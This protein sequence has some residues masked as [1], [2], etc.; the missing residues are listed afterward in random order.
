MTAA[1]HL[2]LP[3]RPVR[4]PPVPEAEL[5]DRQREVLEGVIMGQTVNIYQTLVRH[6][7][8]AAAM[9]NLGRMLRGS[10]LSA[11]D[12]EILILRTGCNC[13]SAY[14]LAQHYRTATEIGMTPDDMVRIRIGPDAPGWDEFEAA[15]CRAAD[16]L[17]VEHTIR[18]ATWQILAAHYDEQQLIQATML[19]GYYHLVSFALNALGVA[20]EP[21]AEAFPVG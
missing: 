12:R 2:V 15:L 8:A 4:L 7:E 11:R 9:V 21:D 3:S 1:D 16:E 20:L 10:A 13:E 19:V 6:P 14:E 5:S 17:H 18:D